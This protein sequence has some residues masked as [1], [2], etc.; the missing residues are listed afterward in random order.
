M[1][2]FQAYWTP[3]VH[4][5]GVAVEL[6]RTLMCRSGYVC[7]CLVVL[8][9]GVH[10]W[11]ARSLACHGYMCM[12]SAGEGSPLVTCPCCRTLQAWYC[13]WRV[14]H[15]QHAL[16]S[17]HCVVDAL[18]VYKLSCEG[19]ALG[20]GCVGREACKGGIQKVASCQKVCVQFS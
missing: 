5:H 9:L 10:T 8:S 17:S 4:L 13:L 14:A 3:R 15:T 11:Q 16:L 7:H 12:M 6:A 19:C 18:R 2:M 1:Q 20:V